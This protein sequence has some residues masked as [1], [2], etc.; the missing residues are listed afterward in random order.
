MVN[1]NFSGW[2]SLS[3]DIKIQILSDTLVSFANQDTV[4]KNIQKKGSGYC[5]QK[6][7][8]QEKVFQR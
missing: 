8:L 7:F 5:G 6:L 2:L 3:E 4:I 1:N